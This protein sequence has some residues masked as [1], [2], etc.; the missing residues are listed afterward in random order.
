V[1]KSFS[2]C[3]V[4][5]CFLFDILNIVYLVEV[6]QEEA[7]SVF[8]SSFSSVGAGAGANAEESPL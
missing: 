3:L 8:F 6:V 7:F 4:F 2:F 5:V 1:F